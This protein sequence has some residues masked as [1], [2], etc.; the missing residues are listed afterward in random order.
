MKKVLFAA[1]FMLYACGA[2]MAPA[3]CETGVPLFETHVGGSVF[4]DACFTDDSSNE[5]VHDATSSNPSIVD[6]VDIRGASVELYA[7]ARGVAIITLI[8]TDGDGLSGKYDVEVTVSN[9]VPEV[10]DQI[11]SQRM[12]R[13]DRVTIDLAEYFNDPDEQPL[14]YL[15][16]ATDTSVARFFIEGRSLL[17][18]LGASAGTTMARATAT[19]PDGATAVQEFEISINAV[20]VNVVF[21]DSFD[22]L[23]PGWGIRGGDRGSYEVEAGILNIWADDTDQVIVSHE[24]AATKLWKHETRIRRAER[25]QTAA[26]VGFLSDGRP[27]GI[28]TVLINDDDIHFFITEHNPNTGAQI[29]RHVWTEPNTTAAAGEYVVV[30]IENDP[31][32]GGIIITVDE[33]EIFLVTPTAANP[34]IIPRTIREIVIVG[35]NLT[36]DD[37]PVARIDV[38]WIRISGVRTSTDA[39]VAATQVIDLKRPVK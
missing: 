39:V 26:G 23:T 38:D 28:Y 18:I 8:G 6:V 20:E 19:D 37:P 34:N 25:S 30:G 10:I 14:K 32:R 15:A 16:E 7:K 2:N 31:L 3:G 35:A 13:G 17:H 9:R 22:S 1:L 29:N 5:L 36:S 33:K 24:I 21:E 4:I 11:T 27:Y 12:D